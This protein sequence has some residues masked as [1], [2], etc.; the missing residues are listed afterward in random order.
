MFNLNGRYA[1]WSVGDFADNLIIFREGR[2]VNVVLCLNPSIDEANMAYGIEKK[3]IKYHFFHTYKEYI[4]K[5]IPK[6]KVP[7]PK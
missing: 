4:E 7:P 5:I 1:I 3:E 2:K 6:I